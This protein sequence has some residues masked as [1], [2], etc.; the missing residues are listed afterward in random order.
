[1]DYKKPN[2]PQIML[3]VA[4]RPANGTAG[5]PFLGTLFHNPGGPGGS[6]VQV[7]LSGE[8]EAWGAAVLESF[9]FVSWDP[10]GV[11]LSTPIT[12]FS[13]MKQY[14]DFL[15]KTFPELDKNGS[16]IGNIV[17][18]VPGPSFPMS[19]KEAKVPTD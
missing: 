2:G 12:C 7:V 19:L 1:M 18:W 10:R 15:Y 14:W 3:A 9:D 5:T 4:K 16:D 17:Q 11:G 6:G 8:Y 13:S